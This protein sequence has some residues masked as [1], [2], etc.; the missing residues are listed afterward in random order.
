M[1]ALNVS[2][3]SFHPGSVYLDDGALLRAAFEMVNAGAALIDIGARSTAPYLATEI[4]EEEE[5]RR[6]TRAVEAL[7]PKVPVPICADTCRLRPVR[8]ALDAGAAVINDV[9]GLRDPAVARLVADRGVGVILMASPEPDGAGG[10]GVWRPRGRGAVRV[11]VSHRRAA[12]S[13]GRRETGRRTPGLPPP[14]SPV[15]TVSMLLRAALRRARDAGISEHRVVVDPGVGFFRHEAVAWP[16]WDVAVLVRLRSLAALGRP[17]CVGVSRKSFI[18]ALTDR[19]DAG[20]RL[21]GSLAATAVAVANGAALIRTHDVAATVDAT[22]V[23]EAVRRAA[24]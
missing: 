24:R 16:E 4:S 3:E 5:A 14:P 1:G 18:G 8:A 6:L 19:R 17:L 23:A 22:R 20:D 11:I 12:R 7:V 9:S 13:H 15:A 10:P 21:A 2:P